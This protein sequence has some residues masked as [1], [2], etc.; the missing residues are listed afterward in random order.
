MKAKLSF[1]ANLLCQTPVI[2]DKA[3]CGGPRVALLSIILVGKRVKVQESNDL[4]FASHDY[5]ELHFSSPHHH[6]PPSVPRSLS[7]SLL[8]PTR[9]PPRRWTR[10]ASGLRRSAPRP[11]APPPDG[12]VSASTP[13]P[14]PSA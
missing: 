2:A 11:A 3:T 14:R 6:S 10:S 7:V 1:C 5:L 13:R 12:E 9:P 4:D 8:I